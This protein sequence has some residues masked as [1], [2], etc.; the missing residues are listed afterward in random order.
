MSVFIIFL[1]FIVGGLLGF[2][3]GLGIN[4]DWE[5]FFEYR[6]EKLKMQLEKEKKHG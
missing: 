2:A 3:L 4:F 1:V 6:L 5:A